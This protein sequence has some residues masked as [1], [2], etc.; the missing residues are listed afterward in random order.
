M[1]VDFVSAWERKNGEAAVP[2][3]RARGMSAWITPR[4][5]I[6]LEGL[7]RYDY[8]EPDRDAGGTKRELIVG[9]AYWIP[10]KAT[11]LTTALMADYDRIDYGGGL[12]SKPERRWGLKALFTF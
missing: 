7:L 2:T 12:T 9:L 3:V 4:T 11:P 8:Y 5:T 10:L 1:G 6:G